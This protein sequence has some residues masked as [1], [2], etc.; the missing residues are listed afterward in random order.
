MFG[1]GGTGGILN[2]VTKKAMVGENFGSF[3][4]GIDSFGGGD[5]AADYNVETGTNT[6]L[7]FNIHSDA[8]ENHRVHYDGDRVGFNPTMRIEFSSATTLDLSYEHADHER[9]I[10]RGI[11]TYNGEPEEASSGSPLYVGMPLS[12]NLS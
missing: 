4:F 1:R 5:L 6:A 11:P 10:D 9:F 12:M 3:D 8:L 7:R 2:R